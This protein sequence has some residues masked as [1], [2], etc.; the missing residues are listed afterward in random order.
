MS[1]R[2]MGH[3]AGDR[4]FR[5]AVLLLVSA[6]LPAG[7]GG[8]DGAQI[9]ATHAAREAESASAAPA[10]SAAQTGADD[11]EL[12]PG[13]VKWL[14][15]HQSADGRWE[16]AGWD[17]WKMGGRVTGERLPGLGSP[18]LDVAVTS[19]VLLAY[20]GAGYTATSRSHLGAV[21][22]WGLHALRGLQDEEGAFGDPQ[23]QM[24]PVNQG[25]A[26]LAL[27][28]HAEGDSD[29]RLAASVRRGVARAQRSRA[30]EPE[31]W[32][33]DP[34]FGGLPAFAWI[35]LASD[36]ARQAGAPRPEHPHPSAT[37]LDLDPRLAEDRATVA[38]W[39]TL[40]QTEWTLA[41]VGAALLLGGDKRDGWNREGP[42]VAAGAWMTD[43]EPRWDATGAGVDAMGWWLASHGAFR[44]GGATWKGWERAMKPAISDT[45]RRDGTF[46]ELKGSWDP[47]G[48]GAPEGGRVFMTAAL[49]LAMEI[50]YRYDRVVGAASS[51]NATG[52]AAVPAPPPPGP[53]EG[54]LP[55]RRYA[56]CK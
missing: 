14:P 33:R 1:A 52:P 22:A 47:V 32:S 34:G 55:P 44:V 28:A 24:W 12:A 13:D 39:I 31:R 26:I 19:L 23:D 15:A 53:A 49:T 37:G 48:A 10:A 35:A 7:C 27:T 4:R 36:Y 54:P 3:G 25:L 51:S 9:D 8:H 29:P 40:P 50:W 5:G 41:R 30:L 2:P 42:V 38:A 11:E 45:Q 18:S 21:V 56:P 17:R 43:H 16:A 6:I 20:D 46:C